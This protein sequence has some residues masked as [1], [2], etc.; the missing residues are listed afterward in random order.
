MGLNQ[1]EGAAAKIKLSRL[2][3]DSDREAEEW[4]ECGSSVHSKNKDRKLEKTLEGQTSE[5]T[6]LQ[7]W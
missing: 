6:Q 4:N 7:G 3:S 5:L 1:S 2:V